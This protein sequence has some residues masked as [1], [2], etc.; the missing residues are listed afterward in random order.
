M[1]ILLFGIPTVY[2]EYN[3]PCNQNIRK[4]LYILQH[5][6]RVLVRPPGACVAAAGP[7]RA[8]GLHL[9]HRLHQ[10]G[11]VHHRGPSVLQGQEALV[12]THQS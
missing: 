1:A 6:G 4:S 5:P 10:R 12:L 2:I 8:D 3:R 9:P 11:E 7:D